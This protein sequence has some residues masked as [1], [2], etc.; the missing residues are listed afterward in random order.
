MWRG[1]TAKQLCHRTLELGAHVR[2][3]HY[4]HGRAD[5]RRRVKWTHG[6]GVSVW[7]RGGNECAWRVIDAIVC[8]AIAGALLCVV[9]IDGM[10]PGRKCGVRSADGWDGLR[11][12]GGSAV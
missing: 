2:K 3:G 6:G 9:L 1:S 5:G 4:T 11:S 12:I 7:R 10:A 8:T